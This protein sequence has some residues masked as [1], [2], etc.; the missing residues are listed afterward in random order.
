MTMTEE[1]LLDFVEAL[2]EVS[3]P[4]TGAI[5]RNAYFTSMLTDFVD[6]AL[7]LLRKLATTRDPQEKAKIARRVQRI[8]YAMKE[9]SLRLEEE[10]VTPMSAALQKSL[11]LLD[12]AIGD[13]VPPPPP[14]RQR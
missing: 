5:Y 2:E 10:V 7:P 8:A 13:Y 12:A 9:H 11:P 6:E 14:D 3:N 1:Q 4:D